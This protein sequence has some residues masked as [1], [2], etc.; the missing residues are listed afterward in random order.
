MIK[1]IKS[2]I[3]K[4]PLFKLYITISRFNAMSARLDYLEKR[5][6]N[7]NWDMMEKLMHYLVTAEI[8]G[9]YC[10][11]GV[12]MG[13]T[14]NHALRYHGLFPHMRYFGFDSFEG[15]P[16]PEGIDNEGNYA[17]NFFKGQFSCSRE[18]FIANI[19]ANNLPLEKVTLVKGWFDTSLTDD[20][21]AQNN[22]KK[23][24]LAY[25]DC[26]FY[27][28][29]V[30]VLEFIGPRLSVGSI[31]AFDDWKTY[32]NLPDKGQQLATAEWLARNPNIKLLP[33]LDYGPFGKVFSVAAI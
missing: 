6:H 25:I 24:A 28:S 8:E 4:T 2:V 23:I 33:L 18:Q 1:T 31:I 14:F 3:K 17:S 10:E 27:H 26:D 15:L 9:D 32:R 21:A 12:F 20:M 7:D 29:T 5:V 11:F 19:K 30:P 22:L 13:T 16:A